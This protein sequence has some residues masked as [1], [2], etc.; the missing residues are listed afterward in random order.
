MFLSK[1]FFKIYKYIKIKIIGL[2]NLL[3][4]YDKKRIK[5][6]KYLFI[7]LTVLHE[8]DSGTGI[9]RVTK[10]IYNELCKMDLSYKI[11][12]IYGMRHGQGFYNIKNNK[13]IKIKEGDFFFGLDL[14]VYYIPMNNCFLNKMKKCKIPIYFFI[15]DMIPIFYPETV[16]KGIRKQYKIWLKTIIHYSGIIGNSKATIDDFN[17]W[18]KKNY[19]NKLK[20]L[21]TNY[22][23]LGT[24]I[25]KKNIKINQCKKNE[26]SFLMVS[27]VEPRKKYDQ[28][29]KS[30]EILW[31][32]KLNVK[33][34]IVGRKGWNNDN[35]CK[36]I[37]SS[38]YFNKQLFWYNK[39]I[40][41]EELCKLY[42]KCTAVI[43]TS[44]AEG[45]GLP[46]I[47]AASFGKPLIIRDIPVFREIANNNAFYFNGEKPENLANN[48]EKWMTLY[49]E[50]LEPK[51]Y[52]NCN[53]W[54]Q[55][56][57]ELVDKIGLRE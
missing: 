47:E 53:S 54:K 55:S 23:H 38:K 44:I 27:T 50:N 17:I 12:P 25:C 51:S 13:P 48:I 4:I 22:V 30:F 45:F 3:N 9:Q 46:I 21:Y 14:S 37:E 35:V 10:N 5:N 41:D 8:T 15:H 2:Y 6:L 11:V 24:D 57:I 36:M 52:F 26:L 18:M 31:Q 29:V 28:L 16:E 40:T 34:I 33:L 42:E 1:F 7:D 20:N 49:K 39:G 32:K 56:T 19:E 43:F